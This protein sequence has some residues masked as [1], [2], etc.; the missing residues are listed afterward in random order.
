MQ[1]QHCFDRR[2]L[3]AA[4]LIALC[5]GATPLASQALPRVTAGTGSVRGGRFGNRGVSEGTVAIA[6]GSH[7]AP[8][9]ASRS[10][11][12][13]RVMLGPASVR[14]GGERG[15]AALVLLDAATG[16][17]HLAFVSAVRSAMYFLPN[18][19]RRDAKLIDVGVRIRQ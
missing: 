16:V 11:P 7:T 8:G 6:A 13:M 1:L 17:R 14:L 4:A 3:L 9:V 10:A 5:G 12:P 19:E 15:H 2:G 18:G